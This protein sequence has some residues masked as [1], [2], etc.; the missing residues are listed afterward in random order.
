MSAIATDFDD[1]LVYRVSAV[2]AAILF[3]TSDAASAYRMRALVS[4]FHSKNPPSISNISE[5]CEII[6]F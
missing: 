4:V 5:D 2:V 1:V 3:V 6:K